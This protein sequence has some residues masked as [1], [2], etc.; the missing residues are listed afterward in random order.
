MVQLF[1]I[2]GATLEGQA[3]CQPRATQRQ[4]QKTL[5][6]VYIQ[7]VG[8]TCKTNHCSSVQKGL[9]CFSDLFIIYKKCE[10]FLKHLPDVST[11]F[12]CTHVNRVWV[13]I[14]VG[15][16]RFYTFVVHFHETFGIL[17]LI[18]LTEQIIG[19]NLFWIILPERHVS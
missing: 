6:K 8:Q 16:T 9:W 14:H 15:N 2:H 17:L 1:R 19:G 11:W 12:I 10:N 18:T 3:V 5:K 13:H 4:I 7:C